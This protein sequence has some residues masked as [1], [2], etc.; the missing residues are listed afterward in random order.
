[1]APLTIR[2]SFFSCCS[3]RSIGYG[4]SRCIYSQRICE[5]RKFYCTDMARDH[6]AVST[7]PFIICSFLPPDFAG[8]VSRYQMV[9]T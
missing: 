7:P 9:K 1:L 6:S 4:G 3:L 2:V 8:K 5:V